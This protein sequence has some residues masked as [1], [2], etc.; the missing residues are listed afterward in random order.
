MKIQ[1]QIAKA[2]AGQ[3]VDL[4]LSKL[5]PHL[6]LRELRR[7]WDALQARLNGRPVAKG[8]FA[9]EGDQLEADLSFVFAPQEMATNS[10]PNAKPA[11]QANAKPDADP[12]ANPD[13]TPDLEP[14]FMPDSGPETGPGMEPELALSVVK[15]LQRKKG[16]LALYKPAGLHSACLSGGRGGLSLEALLPSVLAVSG[17]DFGQGCGQDC[18]QS[19]EQDCSHAP[20]ELF[21]R[22]DCLTTGLV[23]ATENEAAKARCLRFEESGQI[24]KRYFALVHGILPGEITMRQALDTDSRR[25]T[26]VL[27]KDDPSPLRCTLARPLLYFASLSEFKGNG[28]AELNAKQNL[29]PGPELAQS[30]PP[31]SS[32]I[33]GGSQSELSPLPDVSSLKGGQISLQDKYAFSLLEVVIYMG[34]RHQIRAH[35]SFA[36]YPIVGDPLYGSTR[37]NRSDGPEG[38]GASFGPW[39]ADSGQNLAAPRLY[40]HHFGLTMPEF[41]ALCPPP[42][43]K[44]ACN[45]LAGFYP[46]FQ[47]EL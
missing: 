13:V 26:R 2:Q 32:G 12:N 29:L 20:A 24:E 5:C 16:V 25:T 46:A 23:L 37:P 43:G 8:A 33:A 1:H 22:L 10:A 14:D 42:W 44:K 28:E 4:I 11:V 15:V 47:N 3:R 21:N 31:S 35:L 38:P 18:E 39:Q 9:G 30:A 34:A 17:K 27:N 36:G 6:S 7:N 41:V 45:L 40:L 19:F